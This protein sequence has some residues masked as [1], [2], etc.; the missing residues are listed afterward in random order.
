MRFPRAAALLAVAAIALSGCTSSDDKPKKPAAG[1]PP[2]GTSTPSTPLP[3]TASTSPSAIASG[4]PDIPDAF[5]P[6]ALV[7]GLNARWQWQDGKSGD[8]GQKP[9]GICAKADLESIG[10]EK[11]GQRT[12][13]PP[14]DSDDNAA[15]QVASFADAK[16]AAQ[17]WSVLE[18]WRSKCAAKIGSSL[19]PKVGP[20]VAVTLPDGA[21]GRWYLVSWTPEGEETGRFEAFG[22][23]RLGALITVLR[24]TNSGQDYNYPVGKEP[25]VAMVQQAGLRIAAGFGE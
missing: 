13:F 25:M 24:I 21:V 14:D 9:F 18:A 20:E 8:G 1:A 22:M 2:S 12:Y 7:P 4:P 6:T 23:V 11:V 5:L 17:A 16:S 19:G 10:A 3:T 15:Q